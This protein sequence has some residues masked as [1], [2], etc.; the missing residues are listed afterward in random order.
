MLSA[1][2]DFFSIYGA[3]ST[4]GEAKRVYELLGAGEKLN[5]VEADD[6]HGY[7]KP[8]R[9]ASYRWFSRWLKGV[10]DEAPEP[11]VTIA[12][13]EELYCTET[14]QVATSV[15]GETVFSLNQKRLEE[16]RRGGVRSSAEDVRQMV[17][18][19][20]PETP[21]NTQFFGRIERP[22]Y[23]IEKLVYE[24]EPG[25]RVPSLLYIPKEPAGKKA[26]AV[27]LHGQGKAEAHSEVEELAKAGLVVLA[28]DARGLGE[29]RRA[30]D[31]NGSD[32][33]RYFGD[34]ESAMG[35]LLTGKPLVAMRAEDVSRGVDL[36]VSRAEVD[37]DKV[38]AFGRGTGAVPVLY[39]AAF[40]SRI[41]KLALEEMLV[42]YES[43][44]RNRIHRQVFEN[45]VRGALRS[46]DLPDLIGW[47]APRP[48]WVV[49]A[50]DP[51][52]KLVPV[53]EVS[54]QYTRS[55][56]AFQRAGAEAELRILR[57]KPADTAATLYRG[58]L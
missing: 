8:R 32:W 42:S 23:G 51:M 10:D 20:K 48:V 5:M 35:S 4:F 13:P 30:S 6:G 53:G 28:I 46:Y 9:L 3:R 27:F 52:Q 12:T 26:A 16:V 11:E 39:A 36:L 17:K 38:Y 50:V 22:G 33:P 55:R 2:R 31:G 57:R 44:V 54:R 45:I 29:T 56:E 37:R 43:V 41:R 25:I 24:S 21:L 58:M 18:F 49:D 34:Y 47:L 14:G 19:R 40:D 1:I 7:S 15:G